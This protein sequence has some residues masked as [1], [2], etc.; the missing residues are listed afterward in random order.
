MS[1]RIDYPY[2]GLAGAACITGGALLAAWVYRGAAGEAFSPLNHAISELGMVGVSRGAWAFNAGLIVGGALLAMFMLGLGDFLGNGVARVG[3]AVGVFATLA[4]GAVGV[5]P[6]NHLSA[7]ML[8]SMSFFGSGLLVVLLFSLAIIV[9]RQA[10]TS[11]WFALPGVLVALNLMLFLLGPR[12]DMPPAAQFLQNPDSVVRPVLSWAAVAEWMV[13]VL[14]VGWVAVAS[15]Y[16]LNKRRGA[17]AEK[18]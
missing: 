18:R 8:A 15:L 9:D 11:K 3:S 10:K 2:W 4:C 5:F 14:L 17:S 16:R 6:M 13:F 1:Q 7:H 12:P